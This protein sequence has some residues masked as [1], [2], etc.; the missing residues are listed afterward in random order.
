ML[1]EA[2]AIG[3]R[4]HDGYANKSTAAHDCC[5]RGSGTAFVAI[6]CVTRD[7]LDDRRAQKSI[8]LGVA[9]ALA[10]VP[11]LFALS[12]YYTID[13]IQRIVSHCV[14]VVA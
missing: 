12:A 6:T 3:T 9:M 5:I 8:S 4:L 13:T 14:E 7:T 10:N 1:P 11:V 2:I